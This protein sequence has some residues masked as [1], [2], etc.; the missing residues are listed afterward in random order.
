MLVSTYRRRHSANIRNGSKAGISLIRPQNPQK[1]SR[2]ASWP[3]MATPCSIRMRSLAVTIATE[4]SAMGGKQ[5]WIY[6]AQAT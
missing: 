4:A 3:Q 5:I 6:T 2:E 1:P